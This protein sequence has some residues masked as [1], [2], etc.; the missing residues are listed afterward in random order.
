M[1]RVGRHDYIVVFVWKLHSHD[2]VDSKSFNS[3]MTNISCP[4]LHIPWKLGILWW[5]KFVP[6]LDWANC[7]K[8]KKTLNWTHNKSKIF[9]NVQSQILNKKSFLFSNAHQ[10]KKFRYPPPSS[11]QRKLYT[12]LNLWNSGQYLV[13]RMDIAFTIFY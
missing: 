12:S 7:K 4:L 10:N 6:Y 1:S 11:P 8:K 3:Q 2:D 9:F 13:K 5:V